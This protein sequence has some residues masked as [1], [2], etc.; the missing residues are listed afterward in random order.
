MECGESSQTNNKEGAMRLRI[1]LPL[2]LL[3]V[4]YSRL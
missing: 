1:V 2:S 3:T 4:N